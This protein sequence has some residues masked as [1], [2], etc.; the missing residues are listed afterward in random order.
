MA[1][2]AA[3]EILKDKDVLKQIE[4][5]QGLQGFA[6]VVGIENEIKNIGD[7]LDKKKGEGRKFDKIKL[8]KDIAELSPDEKQIIY[9]GLPKL[10]KAFI[11]KGSFDSAFEN[12]F[13]EPLFG[14]YRKNIKKDILK[15]IY[16]NKKNKKKVL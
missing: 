1:A 3:Y 14:K 8:S 2:E 9:K 10:G 12:A 11:A 7:N 5:M 6:S 15:Q 16:Q 4:E 13:P